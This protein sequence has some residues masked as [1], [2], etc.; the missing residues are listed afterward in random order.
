MSLNMVPMIP[1]RSKCNPLKEMLQVGRSFNSLRCV[2]QP[3]QGFELQSLDSVDDPVHVVPPFNSCC[4]IDL[5]RCWVPDPHVVLQEFHGSHSFQS[6]RD[7]TS[8]ESD[9]TTGKVIAR[10]R[11]RVWICANICPIAGNQVRCW[12]RFVACLHATLTLFGGKM[13]LV[14]MSQN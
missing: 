1:N 4:N 2:I 3:G 9:Q 6:H 14:N 5:V 11:R 10:I 7:V 8:E 13:K 12:D